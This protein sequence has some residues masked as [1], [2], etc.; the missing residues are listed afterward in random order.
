MP[1]ENPWKWFVED[2]P[3]IA[4]SALRPQELGAGRGWNFLDYWRNQQGRVWREYQGALGKLALAGQAPSLRYTDF[5]GR[6]PWMD[7][8]Q[9]MPPEQ[10][11]E[12]ASLFG[13]RMRWNI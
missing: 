11:G 2:D 8:W 13:P 5:L 1:E 3:N 9:Q 6:Y 4:Y 7:Y 12:R 10:R